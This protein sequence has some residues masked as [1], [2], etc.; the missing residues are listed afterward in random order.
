VAAEQRA[1]S[2]FDDWPL[3]RKLTAL[4]LVV[5]VATLLLSC[6]TF[7]V[8]D[9]LQTPAGFL[10]RRLRHDLLMTLVSAEL[11]TVLLV[12]ISRRLHERFEAR[13]AQLSYFT[14]RISQDKDYHVRLE[15]DGDD[16]VG[17][18]VESL[19][20]M[21]SEIGK[22]DAELVVAHETAVAANKA[23]SV[24]LANMSHELRTPLN[25]IIGYSEMLS[26]DAQ[27][28]GAPDLVPDL[29]KI[30]AA[31][32]H[33]LGLINDILDL[34][35]IEAGKMELYLETFTLPYVLEEVQSMI[36][37]LIAK[38]SNQLVIEAPA[39]LGEMHADVVKLRQ[40]LF[41]LLSNASKFTKEGTV[42]L[43]VERDRDQFTFAVSDTGIGMTDEQMSKLFGDF[44][45]ADAST[46]RKYG[47]TG[48]GLAISK[49]FA[50]MMGGDITVTSQVDVGST[51]TLVLPARVVD[52]TK[53]DA[54]AVAPQS[55]K[56][57]ARREG[58]VLI[59]VIDDDPGV[60]ELMKRFLAR[61]GYRIE[62]AGDGIEGLRLAGELQPTVITLDVMMP[63]MDGWSVLTQLRAD[64]KMH[65]I[66]VVICSMIDDKNTGYGLGATEYLMKPLNRTQVVR[67]MKRL[68]Q[69][70]GLLLLVEDDQD[71]RLVMRRTLEQDGWTI[72][73]AENGAEALEKVKNLHPD[74]VLL[75]LNMPVMN[76][77]EVIRALRELGP[78]GQV[79]VL[80]VTGNELSKEDH[81][82]LGD[83]VVGVLVK[84]DYRSEE[85]LTQ[86]RELV[87]Q[88]HRDAVQ[89]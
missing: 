83:G 16:E 71:L 58:E 9:C 36:E 51:F 30:H 31:G 41:N 61:E 86:V 82:R 39:D 35:K 80:V 76:G 54:A 12:I 81:E 46:T 17:K 11:V 74:L 14:R 22:R 40:M 37:P 27:D 79:P 23:K 69:S 88:Q 60:G 15:P 77:F 43:A 62:V 53:G 8:S 59:L 72:S 3:A 65:E 28:A 84:G 2:A 45:Q 25:A 19:N 49:R 1:R 52:P 34:S 68:T 85:L 66:P 47:G 42:R 50:N 87:E 67:L 70:A 29:K 48:L 18:L 44:A 33:L 26:E 7:I 56:I 10:A 24:F 75:D 57:A 89:A 6:A 32:T 4:L 5:G 55:G 63:L 38:N 78:A 73:E 20:I 21:L 13:F 64:P